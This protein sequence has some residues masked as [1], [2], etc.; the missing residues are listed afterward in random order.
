MIYGPAILGGSA[1][2]LADVRAL[3]RQGQERGEIAPLRIE[4]TGAEIA[5]WCGTPQMAGFGLLSFTAAETMALDLYVAAD[6]REEGVGRLLALAAIDA[7]RN[8]GIGSL[9]IGV[10]NNA[11]AIRRLVEELLFEPHGV[12]YA[13]NLRE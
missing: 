5:V 2:V 6:A 3:F 12:V 4:P 9:M 13:L 10:S 7:A 8:M 1:L 11:V